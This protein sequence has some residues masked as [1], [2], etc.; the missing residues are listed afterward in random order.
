[1]NVSHENFAECGRREQQAEAWADL[2]HEFRT[3]LS[4]MREHIELLERTKRFRSDSV[5]VMSATVETPFAARGRFARDGAVALAR[6]PGKRHGEFG[7]SSRG[8]F[9]GMWDFARVTKNF[10]EL[11]YNRYEPI[12]FEGGSGRIASR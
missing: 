6:H 5:R 4:I 10:G 8:H 9:G 11:F 2:A 3:P 7:V 12:S 1:M